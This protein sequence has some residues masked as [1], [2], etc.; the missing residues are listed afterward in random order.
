MGGHWRLYATLQEESFHWNLNF[1][2]SPMADSLNFSSATWKI[3]K[4]PSMLAYITKIQKSKL[5]N[6]YFHEFDHSSH[7]C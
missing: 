5:A 2:I 4:N 3:F 7:S 6:I 1:A